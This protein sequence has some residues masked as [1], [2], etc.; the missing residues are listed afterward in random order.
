MHAVANQVE[1]P[2][3]KLEEFLTSRA[4]PDFT[5][6]VRVTVRVLPTAGLE[7]EFT[8]ETRISHQVDRS[9]DKGTP[10]V[11]NVRVARV[12][13]LIREHANEFVLGTKVSEVH[14]SFVAGEI[15][16]FNIVQVEQCQAK[17]LR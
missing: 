4:T 6:T 3:D 13:E 17:Q 14:A 15:R 8:A 9:R 7:V 2:L 11:T 10:L 1:I 5:G 12:R 16:S